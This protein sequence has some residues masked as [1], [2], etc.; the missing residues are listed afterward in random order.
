MDLDTLISAADPVRRITIPAGDPMAARRLHDQLVAKDRRG[1]RYGVP[2]TGVVAAA[3]AAAA[4]VL[5][6]SPASSPVTPASAAAAALTRAGIAAAD[7]PTLTL[8]PGQYLYSETKQ[9]SLF[10]A[11]TAV[12]AGSA[13]VPAI[14]QMTPE[15]EQQ[16]QAADGSGR[17]LITYDGP[18]Q[19]ATPASEQA[20]IQAG[21]PAIVPPS[22]GQSSSTFSGAPDPPPNYSN[23]PTDPAALLNAIETGTTGLPQADVNRLAPSDPTAVFDMAV[24][25]LSQ[26]GTGSTAALRAALYQ[27]IAGLPGIELLGQAT[28]HSGRSGT[29]IAGPADAGTRIEIIIDPTNGALLEQAWVITDPTALPPKFQLGDTA[30]QE[31][32][33]TDYLGSGV[34]NSTSATPT[35]STAAPTS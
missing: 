35:T 30:G 5:L 27:I 16:W 17:Q 1:W 18:S 20:W 22:S 31:V 7:E 6:I 21:K 26:P 25:I 8:G 33:W 23:L 11:A 15:T 14:T 24:Q 9:L 32:D 28:D 13:Q 34:V 4:A 19:F 3:G 2:A 29:Q 10:T 12:P